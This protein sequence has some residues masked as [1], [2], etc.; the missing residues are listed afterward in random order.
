MV[1]D[2]NQAKADVDQMNFN[3]ATALIFAATF[4]HEDI[5]K[6]LLSHGAGKSIK[7][8]FGKTAL[9]YAINQ[10]TQSIIIILEK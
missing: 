3:G 6:Y 9:D 1:I 5:V 8:N 4:G 2:L 10:G 7:D